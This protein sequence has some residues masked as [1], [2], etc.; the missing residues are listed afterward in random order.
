MKTS[1]RAFLA[2]TGVAADGFRVDVDGNLW[3]GM[4]NKPEQNGVMV[5]SPQAKLIGYIHTPE[6]ISNL[7]FGGAKRTRLLMTGSQ[8]LYSLVVDVQGVTIS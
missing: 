1:R 6:R 4:G 2:A 7:T 5:L 3:M 8:S